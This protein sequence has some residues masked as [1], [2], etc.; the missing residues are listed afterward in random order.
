MTQDEFNA[1]IESDFDEQVK[2]AQDLHEEFELKHNDFM[3]LDDEV[4]SQPDIPEPLHEQ[5]EFTYEEI[6]RLRKQEGKD[7]EIQKP[8]SPY[9]GDP[10]VENEEKYVENTDNE[11]VA[12]PSHYNICGCDSMPMIEKI[13]GTE[14]YLG[15]LCGNVWK[16]RIRVGKKQSAGILSDI[17]KA[18]Y[19][20]KLYNDFVKRNTP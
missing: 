19:Y 14:A 8:N 2:K 11:G 5:Q 9:K 15:F 17:K 3:G 18:L 10:F 4:G 12:K 16:Y 6:Q 20:E 13:L 1:Q 7:Y